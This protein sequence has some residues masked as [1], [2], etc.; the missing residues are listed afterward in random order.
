MRKSI[1][2]TIII[3]VVA[4]VC[5]YFYEEGIS[6]AKAGQELQN[7]TFSQIKFIV[8]RVIVGQAA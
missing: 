6:E 8:K 2:I 5:V 3:V 1:I 4:I 7:S